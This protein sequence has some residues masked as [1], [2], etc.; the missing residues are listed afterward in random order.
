MAWGFN[1]GEDTQWLHKTALQLQQEA[2]VVL[3]QG[4]GFQ[5]YYQPTRS[6]WVDE[7]LVDVMAEVARFCR[8]RKRVSFKTQ[9]VPQVAVLLSITTFHARSDSPFGSA[10]LLRPAAGALQGLLE[11]GYSVDVL[12]E[13]TL[14]ERL[15]EYPL[16]V[17]P[18]CDEL[19]ADLVAALRERVKAGGALLIIGAG[20]ARLFRRELGVRLRGEPVQTGSY[21]D[22]DG[23]PVHIPG[24]WQRFVPTS[25]RVV[26]RC[27]PGVDRRRKGEPAASLAAC[28]K[29]RIGAVYGPLASALRACG[30]PLLR[31][32]LGRLARW[33]FPAP[34]VRLSGLPAV[35]LSLRRRGDMLLVHLLNTS[36]VQTAPRLAAL[37]FIPPVGPVELSVRLAKPPREVR[38]VGERGELT[39]RWERGTLRLRLD[40]LRLHAVVAISGADAVTRAGAPA[41]A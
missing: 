26:G 6:G 24:P 27:L 18:E 14:R 16:V 8:A 15:W 21:L 39:S 33:L 34:L 13:H 7:S 1:R 9:T 40:S 23:V 17:L 32:F 11:L 36:V 10:E 38:L 37:D 35:D 2:A 5:I 12:G 30:H 31:G 25:A 3:G 22:T 19:P 41:R 20:A 29:G 4:G 28:G